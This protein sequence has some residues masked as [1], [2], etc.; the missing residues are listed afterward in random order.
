MSS[1]VK[2][3]I[4]HIGSC[5]RDVMEG[6]QEISKARTQRMPLTQEPPDFEEGN[7]ARPTA[8]PPSSQT[9]DQLHDTVKAHFSSSLG[10][11]PY[12][13]PS[14]LLG[15]RFLSPLF[16]CF[17]REGHKCRILPSRSCLL[18]LG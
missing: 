5:F 8:V 9:G 12:N 1:Q 7:P 15:V 11:F 17:H 16:L 2:G 4:P 18:W 3:L 13:L 10:P 14:P 6:N